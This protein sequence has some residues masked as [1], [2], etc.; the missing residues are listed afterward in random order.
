MRYSL[1]SFTTFTACGKCVSVWNKEFLVSLVFSHNSILAFHVQFNKMVNTS[2][3]NTPNRQI[4]SVSFLH[5]PLVIMKLEI[6]NQFFQFNYPNLASCKVVKWPTIDPRS[7]VW[8]EQNVK[9]WV[10]FDEIWPVIDHN[11]CESETLDC[12]AANITLITIQHQWYEKPIET[13]SSTLPV[14]LVRLAKACG[15][16]Q[17]AAVPAPIVNHNYWL[18]TP[19]WNLA[20][21]N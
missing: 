7:C 13:E 2:F 15:W 6:N 1:S 3:V 8:V 11:V 4:L 12:H 16:H 10:E 20:A 21:N 5:D 17:F 9:G 14:R 19:L 18:Q